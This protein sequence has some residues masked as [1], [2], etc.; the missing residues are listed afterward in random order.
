M[1][2]DAARRDNIDKQQPGAAPVQSAH[3][4]TA[5]AAQRAAAARHGLQSRYFEVA[6]SKHARY[7]EETRPNPGN[8]CMRVKNCKFGG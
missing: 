1:F 4:R 5:T 3:S 7:H 6:R 2:N 8:L